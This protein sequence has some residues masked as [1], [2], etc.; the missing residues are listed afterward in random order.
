MNWSVLSAELWAQ[1]L[2]GLV[3]ATLTLS[4]VSCVAVLVLRAA[5]IQSATA[6]RCVWAMVLASGCMLFP[7]TIYTQAEVPEPPSKSVAMSDRVHVE[8]LVAP[9]DDSATIDGAPVVISDQATPPTEAIA[10]QERAQIQNADSYR[11]RVVWAANVKAVLLRAFFLI[12]LFGL[13]W[14]TSR[15]VV[16]YRAV[17][18]QLADAN[19][20]PRSWQHQWDRAY[21]Q[22]SGVKPLTCAF[23]KRRI[24]ML[25]LETVGPALVLTMSGYRLIVPEDTWTAMNV[26]QRRSVLL[27]ES[28]H[29]KR[30]DVIW[31]LFA[32]LIATTHWFNPFAW[33]AVNQFEAAGEFCCDDIASS[34]NRRLDF[35]E[36][37]LTVARSPRAPL[38]VSIGEPPLSSRIH[39]VVTSERRRPTT[40][41]SILA[42]ALLFAL[43]CTLNI[44]I[45]AAPQLPEEI[46]SGTSEAKASNGVRFGDTHFSLAHEPNA[47]AYSPD[48]KL[49]AVNYQYATPP[50]R[51]L[52]TSTGREIR[53]YG[54]ED[55]RGSANRM[56]FTPDSR[57]L[58]AFVHDHLIVWDVASGKQKSRT[59]LGKSLQATAMTVSPSGETLAVGFSN[60]TALLMELEDIEDG[61]AKKTARSMKVLKNDANIA[62]GA[63]P[64]GAPAKGNVAANVDPFGG[65]QR[66][67][68]E[69]RDNLIFTSDGQHLV[70]AVGGVYGSIW[71]FDVG[72][73]ERTRT[74]RFRATK[75]H[76]LPQDVDYAFLV[77]DDSILIG[78]HRKQRTNTQ[79]VQF[80]TISVLSLQQW[81]TESGKLEH[82][83]TVGDKVFDGVRKDGMRERNA[84]IFLDWLERLP[85]AAGPWHRAAISEDRR[86]LV[87][88]D[89]AQVHVWDLA[90]RSLVARK[91]LPNSTVDN[92]VGLSR[93]GKTLFRS[94]Y[95]IIER[96]AVPTLERIEDG[97]HQQTKA[98][99]LAFSKDGNRIFSGHKNG[100]ICCWNGQTRELIQHHPQGGLYTFVFRRPEI[101]S[102][103]VSDKA[104]TVVAGSYVCAARNLPAGRLIEF[105]LLTGE[106]RNQWDFNKSVK[107]VRLGPDGRKVLFTL[108]DF[109]H[110]RHPNEVQLMD[111]E[112]GATTQLP[113]TQAYKKL[114]MFPPVADHFFTDDGSA[115]WVVCR[116]GTATKYDSR[117]FKQLKS[118][119]WPVV[120]RQGANPYGL[121]P[122]VSQS[123]PLSGES[124]FL[125][126]REWRIWN[127][128]NN[129]VRELRTEVEGRQRLRHRL[130]ISNDRKMLAVCPFDTPRETKHKVTLYDLKTC[131]QRGMIPFQDH[132]PELLKFTPNDKQIAFC[133]DDG[134]FVVH[135]VPAEN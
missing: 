78:S 9:L 61:R 7:L 44:R 63:D 127:L 39:R 41:R 99:A 135:Q 113:G 21:A 2:I 34:G 11:F 19:P 28:A 40:L 82:D 118:I 75:A 95:N 53:G 90:D 109:R 96:F 32:R 119:R 47:L 71:T 43:I 117:T 108:D 93:D 131:E 30:R 62:D 50:I 65:G 80:D 85:Y 116:E 20:A 4:V 36:A 12:W 3:R 74:V 128:S 8:T 79:L 97:R 25:V 121:S 111:L 48:S 70:W 60:R 51:V 124:V 107:L 125:H 56:V 88:C 38:M 45:D 23:E 16:Q 84:D 18:Y 27:H 103:D 76:P 106:L 130:A 49:I 13:I 102:I 115:I 69:E 91:T 6:R 5:R 15:K 114:R 92:E 134:T 58:L 112:S 83:F 122:P 129:T 73:G 37:L 120:E 104:R 59:R 87:T 42:G 24:P 54:G 133:Y 31:S 100:D 77:D 101:R 126:G 52:S 86:I 132:A 68:V 72:S 123:F 105:D 22:L 57:R 29:L 10:A 67:S 81:N 64:F 26:R 110:S 1:F 66:Q 89:R 35:A 55:V 14:I 46:Q 33:Y 17:L 98:M 94:N